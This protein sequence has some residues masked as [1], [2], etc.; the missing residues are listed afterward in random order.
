M[1]VRGTAARYFSGRISLRRALWYHDSRP[2]L[3]GKCA[4]ERTGRK[5]LPG[6]RQ[7]IHANMQKRGEY[8]FVEG[9]SRV[10]GMIVKKQKEVR[11][12]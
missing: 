2:L 10:H 11:I 3:C 9:V 7:H 5:N 1:A 8:V 4:Q 6:P 12:R